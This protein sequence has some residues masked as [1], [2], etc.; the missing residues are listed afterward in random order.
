[1]NKNW[2][3]NQITGIAIGIIIPLVTSYLIFALRYHGGRSYLDF[4]SAM[5]ILNSFGKLLSISVLP[6]LLA[7]FISIWGEKLKTSRGILTATL[8]Y[9]II[10]VILALVL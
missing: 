8:F 2:L 4:I 6:N 9:G 3:N 10:T 7:F 5:L 1:M